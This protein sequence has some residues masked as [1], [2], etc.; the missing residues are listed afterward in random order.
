[1]LRRMT[2]LFLFVT[3]AITIPAMAT[4]L[5]GTVTYAGG[6]I[7]Q[8]FPSFSYG[9]AAAINTTTREWAYGTVDAATGTYQI[10]GLEDGPW[11]LRVLFGS[12]NF[13]DRVQVQ[14]GELIASA[15]FDV[16]GEPTVMLDL[17]ARYG[18]QFT[19]PYSGVWPG[20]IS[21]C[22]AGAPLPAEVT[23]AWD[24]VPLADTYQLRLVH[25]DCDGPVEIDHVDSTGTSAQVVQGTVQGEAYI[26][27]TLMAY[28]PAGGQLAANTLLVY[29]N[30]ATESALIH[31]MEGSRTAHPP[32][33]TFIPQVAR[34]PG[35]GSSFWTSDVVLSNPTSAAIVA[36]LT[37][38]PR[39]A[40]GL[41]DYMRGTVELPGG[42]CRVVEDV[43]GSVFGT[44]G[45]GSL[46]I[47]PAAVRAS[48]RISTPG[49]SGGSYGQGFPATSI[50]HAASLAGPVTTLG[51]GGVARG[52]FRANLAITE[53]W[54][55]T[56]RVEVTVLDRDGATVGSVARNLPP[57]GNLQLND[58][59]GLVGGPPVLAE[60]RVT[61][62]VV[63]GPGRV[64]SALSLVDQVTG[65]PT[66][67]VLEP[68]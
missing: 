32:S 4:D 46:E 30:G 1:M 7:A 29:D 21:T 2:P 45:A 54:G 60:G 18:Y 37:F 53:V 28:G 59:V 36:T 50:D 55:E 15:T 17:E 34:L 20:E 66:T 49:A 56:A 6:P 12:E 8:T 13:A 41:D 39:G 35:V 16:A 38:T 31:L 63:D 25:L 33:S 65:D 24:P 14:P 62:E 42:G 22:P 64:V 3:A 61:V 11:Y 48:S 5:S 23:F 67:L 40:D 9:R 47:S 44:T 26:A 68:E 10:S 51:V 27:V 58:V 57:F 52:T 19:Q 43:V